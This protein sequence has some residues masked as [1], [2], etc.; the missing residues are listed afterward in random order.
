MRQIG[1]AHGFLEVDVSD[2]ALGD[3]RRGTEHLSIAVDCG[4]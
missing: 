3:V 4:A 1:I 2:D